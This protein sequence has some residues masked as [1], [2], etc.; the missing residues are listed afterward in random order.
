MHL[1][2][3]HTVVTLEIH[4]AAYQDIAK[5]LRDAGYDHAFSDDGQIDMTGIAV[6]SD[7]Q[8][9][10]WREDVYLPFIRVEKIYSWYSLKKFRVLLFGFLPIWWGEY[11]VR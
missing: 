4:D 11:D 1:R 5:K 7:R 9:G 2:Q 3:T 6:V 10:A 8:G